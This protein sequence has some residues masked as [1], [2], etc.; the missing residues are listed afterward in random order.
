[1]D[2]HR[3]PYVCEEPG[4]E[5]LRGFTYSGG[6]HRHQRE[7]HRQHG[8][9]RAKC[10]CPHKDCK[11]STGEGFTRKEN[12]AEHLR[13]VH[14]NDSQNPPPTAPQEPEQLSQLPTGNA[15]KRRRQVVEESEEDAEGSQSSQYL[16]QEVK[17]LRKELK[18]KDD[19]LKRLEEQFAV[20]ARTHQIGGV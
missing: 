3:R 10:F 7:V 16:K 9:P 19:R 6:L 20:L 14:R 5:N 4:C 12:L 18:E 13:R 8:G 11:R 2:K 15:R 1:M 17:K